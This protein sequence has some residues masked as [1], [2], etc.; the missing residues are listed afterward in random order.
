MEKEKGEKWTL[1]EELKEK[2]IELT[3]QRNTVLPLSKRLSKGQD[4]RRL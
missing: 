1:Y 4:R 3:Q 2:E